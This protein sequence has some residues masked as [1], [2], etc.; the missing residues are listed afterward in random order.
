MAAITWEDVLA[1]APELTTTTDPARVIFLSYANNALAVS[2]WG[3]EASPTLK[4]ARCYLAAHQ[5]A[6]SVA[7]ATG[8]VGPVTSESAGGLSRS[9]ASTP[10]SSS[11][12]GSTRYGQSWVEL[13]RLTTARVGGVI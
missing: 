10:A 6:S 12:M 9:Y 2:E 3:G 7:G 8:A 11:E 5:A 1:V 4:L 13:A